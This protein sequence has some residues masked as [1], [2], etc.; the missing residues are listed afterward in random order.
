MQTNANAKHLFSRKGRNRSGDRPLSPLL[1]GFGGSNK[2]LKVKTRNGTRGP[3]PKATG[4]SE[5]IKLSTRRIICDVTLARNTGEPWPGSIKLFRTLECKK[6][7]PHMHIRRSTSDISVLSRDVVN[8]K[9]APVTRKVLMPCF[10][11]DSHSIGLNRPN[12]VLH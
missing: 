1:R 11:S 5:E 10:A 7:L 4:L 6:D 9:Y 2:V 12:P 8:I 3:N